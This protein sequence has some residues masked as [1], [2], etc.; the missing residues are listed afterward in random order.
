ME[1]SDTMSVHVEHRRRLT[2]LPA[3]HL[4]W[5]AVGLAAA[6][7]PLVF[8]AGVV[9]LAAAIGLLCALGGGLAALIAIVREHER[10]LTV[11]LALVPLVIAL[12][13]VLVQ[14]ISGTP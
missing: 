3:T 9:P 12:A 2:I 7:L 1:R 5:W 13:F 6:F 11:L 4:G 8:A 14:V 10:A